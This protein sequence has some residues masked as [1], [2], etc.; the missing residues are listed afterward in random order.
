M[1]PGF[2]AVV[3]K[4]RWH[5]RSEP[6]TKVH[7]TLILMRESLCDNRAGACSNTDSVCICVCVCMSPQD[8]DPRRI[9]GSWNVCHPGIDEDKVEDDVV[10]MTFM[11]L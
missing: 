10:F 8:F 1:C 9:W 11:S 7:L 4:L 6:D 3:Q 2:L 5:P